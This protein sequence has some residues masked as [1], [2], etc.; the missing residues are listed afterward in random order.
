[1]NWRRRLAELVAAGGALG[2]CN[3]GGGPPCGNANPDPCICDRSPANSQQCVAERNCTAAGGSWE[4]FGSP[5]V[6]G[7]PEGL[8]GY[9]VPRDAGVHD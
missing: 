5:L 9:C 3:G 7:S 8:Q 6:D 1:M 2:G 4:F